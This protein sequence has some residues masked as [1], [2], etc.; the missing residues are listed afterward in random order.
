MLIVCLIRKHFL[1][2]ISAPSDAVAGGVLKLMK[3]KQS[4]GF[5]IAPPSTTNSKK[6]EKLVGGNLANAVCNIYSGGSFSRVRILNGNTKITNKIYA[7]RQLIKQPSESQTTR[8]RRRRKKD[9][10]LSRKPRRRWGGGSR[11]VP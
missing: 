8:R 3:F 10:A 9:A 11:G 7:D 5:T 2:L 1:L 4:S 6:C